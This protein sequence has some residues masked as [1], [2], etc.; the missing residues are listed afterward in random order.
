MPTAR[1]TD[2]REMLNDSDS[3]ANPAESS[4]RHF[5]TSLTQQ[6]ERHHTLRQDQLKAKTAIKAFNMGKLTGRTA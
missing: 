4:I 6:S 3:D 2:S 5:S 1:L